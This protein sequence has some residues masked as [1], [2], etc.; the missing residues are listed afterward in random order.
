MGSGRQPPERLAGVRPRI[1]SCAPC[2][3]ERVL[4]AYLGA[5]PADGV[6]FDMPRDWRVLAPYGDALYRGASIKTTPQMYEFIPM[7]WG[8]GTGLTHRT[9]RYTTLSLMADRKLFVSRR[10]VVRSHS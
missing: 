9:A 5:R 3:G 8:G 7:A 4:G 6:T 1:P 10:S 2:K